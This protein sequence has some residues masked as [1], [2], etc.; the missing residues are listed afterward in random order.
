M[1]DVEDCIDRHWVSVQNHLV[2]V[3][4]A[5]REAEKTRL[6]FEVIEKAADGISVPDIIRQLHMRA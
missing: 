3:E 4:R 5:E 1:D 2:T 6:V